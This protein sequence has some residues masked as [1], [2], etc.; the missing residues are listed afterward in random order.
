MHVFPEP[1][2][3]MLKS[4]L[5]ACLEFETRRPLSH[6]SQ[7]HFF[8]HN[9]SIKKKVRVRPTL[10]PKAVR[11]TLGLVGDRARRAIVIILRS[12]PSITSDLR[13][14]RPGRGGAGGV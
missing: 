2:D 3:V 9:N 8:L 13:S 5:H 4:A 14:V 1:K 11:S 10:M 6:L 12:L 7:T